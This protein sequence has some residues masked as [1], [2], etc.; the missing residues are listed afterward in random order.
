MP[1]GPLDLAKAPPAPV[2]LDRRAASLDLAELSL[3]VSLAGA[4]ALLVFLLTRAFVFPPKRALTLTELNTLLNRHENGGTGVFARKWRKRF[5]PAPRFGDED[6]LADAGIEEPRGDKH[7][8]VWRIRSRSPPP[9]L[10]S[11][12]KRSPSPA[13]AQPADG[14]NACAPTPA[15]AKHVRL[16]EPSLAELETLRARWASPAMQ[17]EQGFGG[18]GG[19][20]STREFMARGKG[21]LSAA[22]PASGRG[23]GV[24]EMEP[25]KAIPA[26]LA[27][28]EEAAGRDE[29]QTEATQSRRPQPQV[30]PSAQPPRTSSNSPSPMGRRRRALSPP[31]LHPSGRSS[32]PAF[33][34]GLNSTASKASPSRRRALSPNTA[35]SAGARSHSASPGPAAERAV[36]RWVRTKGA[37][38][39]G[40]VGSPAPARLAVS[41]DSEEEAE[42][43]FDDA[44]SEVEED[45]EDEEGERP[46][47]SISTQ[48][49]GIAAIA[50]VL[51]PLP[52]DASINLVPP[53]SPALSVLSG[54][55][56][57]Q[58]SPTPSS[59]S[60]RSPAV[61]TAPSADA[62]LVVV[63]PGLP[64]EPSKPLT[65]VPSSSSSSLSSSS[66]ATPS[67][68][69]TT[70]TA[71]S[72]ASS[73]ASSP[74][75]SIGAERR[76]S[77]RVEQALRDKQGKR[78]LSGGGGGARVAGGSAL[79]A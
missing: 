24:G 50:A 40:R 54:G 51:P 47:Q 8:V 38:G 62:A 25:G 20:R 1:L 5:L 43:D 46:P 49:S 55:E 53:D 76:L 27:D 78:R 21:A 11:C 70:S 28:D 57:P 17:G 44:V 12:L 64:A 45:D 9:G 7:M 10:R 77:L 19:F 23:D 39:G 75:P 3:V 31:S 34:V 13:R 37:A 30:R 52:S 79:T 2:D 59:A 16:A 48:L 32:S 18:I 6:V 72:T 68:T 14:E 35:S 71:L 74:S 41:I 26:T 4:L 22:K 63:A 33:I 29:E 42:I 69:S 58:D 61:S 56:S 66:L 73:A 15:T 36:P 65:A 67:S 60:A